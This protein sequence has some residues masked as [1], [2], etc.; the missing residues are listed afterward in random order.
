MESNTIDQNQF[1]EVSLFDIDKWEKEKPYGYSDDQLIDAY[2][3]GRKRGKNEA[4]KIIQKIFQE[5]LDKAT[6][7]AEKL[8]QKLQ[9][10]YNISIKAMHLK[11]KDITSFSALIAVD[12]ST[13]LS[14]EMD[15]VYSMIGDY[16]LELE[17]ENFRMVFDFMGT[18]KPLNKNALLSDGYILRYKKE[19]ARQTQ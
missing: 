16:E 13:Y 9:E 4:E 6:S 7:E 1:E 11:V 5:S 14:E 12:E 18:E 15:N 19:S 10:E 17:E 8:V 3:I 2:Q